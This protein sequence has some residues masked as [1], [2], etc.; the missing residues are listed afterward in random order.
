MRI[1]V[2][3][4]ALAAFAAGCAVAPEPAPA[5]APPVAAAAI[6]DRPARP[7]DSALTGTWVPVLAEL[8]GQEFKFGQDFRLT[9][10]GD[11]YEAAGGPQ[12]D[13]GRLEFVV[14][15]P[16][17]FDVVGEDG[18]NKGQRFQAIY[19]LL[20]DGRLEACY[21]LDGIGRPAA[22]STFPGTKLFR[23]IYRRR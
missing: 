10:Q 5:T 13:I 17:A 15:D 19:R 14:G 21:D 1:E 4:L 11:R 3:F 8:G 7:V 22:F 16:K 20:P 6:A 18:P 12:K 9:V 23:V 2:A